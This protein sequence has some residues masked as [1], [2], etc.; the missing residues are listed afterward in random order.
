MEVVPY[1]ASLSPSSHHR[2]AGYEVTTET[3]EKCTVN[4]VIRIWRV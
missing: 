1:T 2:E 3:G 4:N